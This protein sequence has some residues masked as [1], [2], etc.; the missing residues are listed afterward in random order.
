MDGYIF[1]FFVFFPDLTP[2]RRY[3]QARSRLSICLTSHEHTTTISRAK[4]THKASDEELPWHEY[5]SP[6]RSSPSSPST[7]AANPRRIPG[8]RPPSRCFCQRPGYH[9]RLWSSWICFVQPLQMTWCSSKLS[10][11]TSF[12]R[13]SY[14][15]SALWQLFFFTRGGGRNALDWTVTVALDET[16]P[17]GLVRV[18]AVLLVVV[19][20]VVGRQSSSALCVVLESTVGDARGVC[21][22]IESSTS[23]AC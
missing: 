13:Y 14:R 12:C 2:V 15:S 18:R 23:A 1:V 19:A 5:P 22:R 7:C 10:T 16:R 11:Q 4:T 9:L 8:H 17:P 6:M 3:G 20:R 21:S